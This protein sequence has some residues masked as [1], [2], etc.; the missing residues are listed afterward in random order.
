MIKKEDKNELRVKRHVRVRNKISG[1]SNTPRLAV[2]R[3][4]NGIYA[5]IIDDTTK[6]TLVSASTL[7]KEIVSSKV[8]EGKNRKEQAAIV[9]ETIAKRAL[10]KNI[11]SVVFDRGGYVYTGRVEALANA[12]RE[13]GLEF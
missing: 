12:A 11:K 3:S 13:A 5:Q 1:T 8:L 4:L 10:A 6:S 2:Y 7:D 9:G